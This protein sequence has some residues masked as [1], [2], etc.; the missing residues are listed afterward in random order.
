MTK[1][2]AGDRQVAVAHRGRKRRD[3]CATH[4]PRLT[5]SCALYFLQPARQRAASLSLG[6]LPPSGAIASGNRVPAS[7]GR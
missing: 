4:A 6:N 1:D 5:L 2:K 7:L 3:A